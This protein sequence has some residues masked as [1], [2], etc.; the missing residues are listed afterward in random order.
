M[1]FRSKEKIQCLA[2]NPTRASKKIMKIARCKSSII[3][4]RKI[5]KK[6]LELNQKGGLNGHTPFSAYLAFLSVLCA[7]L[8]DFK[9]IAFSNERSS[10]EGNLKYLGRVINHQYSKSF[11]F[12][13][14]FRDYSKKYLAKN[15]E[16]FSFLRPLYEIQI[17]KIFSKYPQYLNAFLSCNEAYKTYSGKKKPTRKWCGNAPN[18][19]LSLSAFV[20]SSK[21]KQLEFL[22]RIYLQTKIFCL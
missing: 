10:N 12:E 19:S 22:E 1:L 16:Y 18:A 5:D 8:F 13:K 9:F 3:V 11:D 6:L 20:L 4:E 15:V 2:L 17:A 14:K 21:K 7:V